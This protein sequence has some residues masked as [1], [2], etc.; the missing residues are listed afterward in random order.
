MPFSPAAQGISGAAARGREVPRFTI[1]PLIGLKRATRA[2]DVV[3]DKI[4]EAAIKATEHELEKLLADA[5]ANT[6]VDTG[7]LQRSG[8]VF[9]PRVNKRR[10]TISFQVIFGG[11]S[12]MGR[13]VDYAFIVHETHPTKSKFLHNA[14]YKFLPGLP[15]K[16]SKAIASVRVK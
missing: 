6:P 1:G 3:G 8:R 7:R 13:F 15:G 14:A 16:V 12:V 2:L 9:K 10:G 4:I 5:K 11:I